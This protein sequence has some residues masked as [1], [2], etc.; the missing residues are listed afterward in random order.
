[1]EITREYIFRCFRNELTA[2]EK[3]A[4]D[5]WVGESE[6]NARMYREAL[7]EFEYLLVNG[8]IDTIR[9][10]APVR[11]RHRLRIAARVFSGAA[12]APSVRP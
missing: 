9:D 3:A 10:K 12:A 6:A 7:T 5:A 4:L 1:M 11:R 8:N 2:R